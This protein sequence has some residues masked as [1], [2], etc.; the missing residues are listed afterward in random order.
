MLLKR[1]FTL[2]ICFTFCHLQELVIK[3]KCDSDPSAVWVLFTSSG[4]PLKQVQV[5]VKH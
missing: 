5:I 4:K 3:V 1:S 2:P